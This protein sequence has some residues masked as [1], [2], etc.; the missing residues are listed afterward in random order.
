MIVLLCVAAATA[1]IVAFLSTRPAKVA[2]PPKK[3]GDV[4]E[5]YKRERLAAQ[6]CDADTNVDL[7]EYLM[8]N[9]RWA[10]ALDVA[11][12]S[13]TACGELGPMKL[14]ILQCHQQLHH[15]TEAAA[16]IEELLVDEPRSTSKWWWHGETWRYREQ[17]ALALVDFR[18]SLSNAYWDRGATAVKLFMYA[19]EA[20][21]IPCEADRAWRYYSTRL[22]GSIDDEGRN[23]VLAL[24]RDKTC[25]AE[26][27]T[28]R[29]RLDVGKKV[30][31]TI[32]GASAEL[33]IDARAG[34]TILSREVAERAGLVPLTD[35]KTATLWSD[36][37]LTGQPARVAKLTL[38][39]L[40]VQN[41][42]VVISDDLAMGDDGVVG[43][44]FLWHFEFR[45]SLTPDPGG[46]TSHETVVVESPR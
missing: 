1:G 15:W 27:G 31:A 26:V 12:M 33:M 22:G 46:Q 44:S 18:Q 21:K 36:V 40:S 42:E 3:E 16:M 14:R 2:P 6:P 23:L 19:A 38:G 35:A 41:V 37:R 7:V 13:L 30:K 24:E 32:D 10:D 20:M 4:L 8:Q 9:Q 5:K 29:A 17:N 34:T 39:G 45:R 25:V 43:L 11:Q 28:G